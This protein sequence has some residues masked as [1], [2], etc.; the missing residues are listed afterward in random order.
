[1]YIE[2]ELAKK[3]LHAIIEALKVIDDDPQAAHRI[4]S[5]I[6]NEAYDRLYGHLHIYKTK[7][8]DK[9]VF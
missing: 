5:D 7:Y 9:P 3:E 4:L 8:S 1:M 2:G 6:A